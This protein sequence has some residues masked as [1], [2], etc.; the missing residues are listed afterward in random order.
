MHKFTKIRPV[1]AASLI[2]ASLMTS[3]SSKPEETSE[4][5]KPSSIFTLAPGATM[6]ETSGNG[7]SQP[8]ES[9]PGGE[10]QPSGDITEPSAT[11]TDP[12]MSD[13]PV[14]KLGALLIVGDTGY[15]YYN[16]VESLANKYI[17]IVSRAGSTLQGKANVY[18][19]IIP[20]SMDITLPQSVRETVTNVSDQKK[21]ID[22]MSGSM[23][24][25]KKVEIFDILKNH[26]N[27][28]I[29]YRNDHHWTAD[30]A[31]YAYQ[32]FCNVR[33]RGGASLDTD[34]TKVQYDGF[35]GTFFNDSNKDPKLNN[36]DTVTAYK[37]VATNHIDIIQQSG[38]P[39]SWNIVTDVSTWA[40]SSKY[41]TFIGGDNPWSVINN[42]NKTDGSACLIIKDSFGNAF[43]PFLVPDYQYVYVLDF[44]YYKKIFNNKL[45]DV[46][47]KYGIQDVIIANNISATRNKGLVAA[48][49]EFV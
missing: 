6:P 40:S 8:G 38:E 22:Y 19:M 49:D 31:W 7:E 25:V 3:C 17:E 12:D 4:T 30:G 43:T 27:E 28:Y 36:P 41:N 48:L 2:A 37:P 34:F 16:F 24:N 26:R 42:P 5:P 15:E 47:T 13:V 14:E 10:T 23:T 32:Q 35:K 20:T 33:G 1:I 29:Y 46:V 44:R 18:S 39:L 9:Q 11:I 21:A 45:I